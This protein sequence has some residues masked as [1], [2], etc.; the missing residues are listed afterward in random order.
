RPSQLTV[1][2]FWV[3]YYSAREAFEDA[4]AGADSFASLEDARSDF[5][6][7]LENIRDEQSDKLNNMPEG[8]QQGSTGELLQERYDGLDGV[9]SDLQGVDIP[10]DG[11]FEQKE[12]EEGEEGD[13]TEEKDEAEENELVNDS[14]ETFD[15]KLK[16]VRSELSDHEYTGS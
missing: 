13:E 15:D 1:S 4:L 9:I 2:D 16:E 6:S 5:A 3:A 11:D 14:G 12:T 8:L 10:D 7:E